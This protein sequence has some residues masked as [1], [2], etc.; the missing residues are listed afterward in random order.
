MLNPIYTIAG[1]HGGVYVVDGFSGNN[2]YFQPKE[3]ELIKK[4]YEYS[5]TAAPCKLSTEEINMLADMIRKYSPVEQQFT[6]SHNLENTK[7]TE[8][9]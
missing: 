5:K 1:R 2:P 7:E 8:N 3:A 6:T 9:T 4:I